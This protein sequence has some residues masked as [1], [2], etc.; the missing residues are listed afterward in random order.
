MSYFNVVMA[1][2]ASLS[3]VIFSFTTRLD[4]RAHVCAMPLSIIRLE[5]VLTVLCS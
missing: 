2:V 4:Q 3:L 1:C 5:R